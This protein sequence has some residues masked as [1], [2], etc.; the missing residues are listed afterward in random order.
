MSKYHALHQYPSYLINQFG[1]ADIYGSYYASDSGSATKRRPR[2]ARG[3]PPLRKPRVVRDIFAG[4]S[5]PVKG[6]QQGQPMSD[7]VVAGNSSVKQRATT[8]RKLKS[9]VVGR[10]LQKVNDS[11]LLRWQRIYNYGQ[12]TTAYPP[13]VDQD[14]NNASG[15]RLQLSHFTTGSSPSQVN[16]LPV[17]LW[18]LTCW[19]TEDI[20]GTVPTSPGV[21]RRLEFT[22]SN[23]PNWRGVYTQFQ[24]HALVGNSSWQL[25]R[26]NLEDTNGFPRPQERKALL[27]W[28]DMRFCFY[29][30]R[31]HPTR[32]IIELIQ[33]K[34]EK[35][36]MDFHND[37]EAF[38]ALST[39]DQQDVR[40]FWL[41]ECKKLVYHPLDVQNFKREK[42]I[43]CLYRESFQIA[44]DDTT[45]ADVCPPNVVKKIFKRFNRLVNWD[46]QTPP[47]TTDTGV[48]AN[49]NELE[50]PAYQVGYQSNLKP[51]ADPKARIYL[52]IRAEDMDP[53]PSN[54]KLSVPA[55]AAVTLSNNVQANIV[56]NTDAGRITDMNAVEDPAG[57]YV[58]GYDW[59]IRDAVT[60]NTPN[61]YRAMLVPRYCQAP[62]TEAQWST[63]TTPSFDVVIRNKWVLQQ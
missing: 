2:A 38:S 51:Y 52:Y 18:D 35:Y 42:A 26:S 3:L 4:G 17:Y 14:G 8:K 19:K 36:S 60:D 49:K 57:S 22:G 15:G 27:K 43:T 46:W 29:G 37:G 12:N 13:D 25:E 31:Q 59:A 1:L 24:T 21:C 56:K 23:S 33:F 58:C 7:R 44:P 45:N 53:V 61:P 63:T 34:D 62:A 50:T 9:G 39:D 6:E 5:D 40:G 54:Q 48:E 16:V 32:I 20:D 41:E 28:S 10:K 11:L 47:V 55:V 30:A